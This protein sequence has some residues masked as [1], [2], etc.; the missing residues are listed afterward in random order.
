MGTTSQKGKES[1]DE[2]KLSA[3]QCGALIGIYSIGCSKL[4][5]LKLRLE[6]A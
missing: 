3:S 1:C 4:T 6:V 5:K 2:R